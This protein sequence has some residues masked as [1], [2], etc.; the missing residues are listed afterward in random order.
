MPFKTN[1]LACVCAVLL[2]LVSTSLLAQKTVTGRVTSNADKQPVAGAT[3]QVKGTK[4]ATQTG[5]DGTFTITSSKD[6]GVLVITVVGFEA[7]QVPVS[8]RS[9]V[10]D[11]VLSL[12]ATSLNDVVV[13]GYTAQKKKEITGAI[14]VVN[15]KDLKSVPAGTM[16]Q[17]LQ[18]QAAG[19]NI[20]T[21]GNP[22]T[23]SDVFIRGITSFGNVAPLVVV[24]GVQ[25]APGDLTILTDLSA[26]DIESIQVLKDAQSSIYGTRGSAGV[27]LVTTKRGRGKASI[28]YDGYYGTQ[29]PKTGNVWHKANTQ[30][31]AD[32][33]FLAAQNSSA[34]DSNGNVVS[35]QYGTGTT[36]RLPDYIKVGANSGQV[37]NAGTDLSLYN[38]DYNKGPIY[39]IVPANTKGGGTDW[40]GAMMKP[41]PIQSHTVTASGGSDRS[42]YLFSVNYFDQEGTMLNTYLKRYA[43]RMN[44]LFNVKNNIRIGENAYVL[45]KQ[46]PRINNNTEG[47]EITQTAW[48]QPIIPVFDAGGGFGGTAGS[49]LGNTGSPMAARVRAASNKDFDWQ[50]TGDVFAEVDFLKHFTIKTLFGGNFENYYNY[51]HGFHTYEN[52]ENSTTNTYNSTSGYNSTWNWTNTL[53]YGNIFAEKHSLKV[54][55][56]YESVQTRNRYMTAGRLTYFSDDPNYVQLATGGGVGTSN[57]DYYNSIHLSSFLAKLDYAYNDKYLLG[58]NY[59]N[60]GASV[61][62]PNTRYG[63]FYSVSLG[64]VLSQ[65]EFMKG[66]T[67]INNLKVRG[68]YGILGSISNVAANNQYNLYAGTPGTT[69]YDLAGASSSSTVG[70]TATQYGNLNTGWEKDK[71]LDIGMDAT[72]INNHLDFSFDW[73]QKSIDGLL[74]QDQPPAVV[75]GATP[76]QVNI[77]DMQNTGFDIT[78][79]YHTRIARDWNFNIGANIGAYK[80][81]IVSIPGQAGFFDVAQTHNTGT[82]VR[83]Q[84]GHPVGSFFGYK[85]VGIFQDAADV[86]K[87]PTEQDAAPGRFKYLDANKDGVIDD[88]D[89]VFYGNPNP[90]FVYGINVGLSWRQLDFSAMFYGSQGNSIFNYQN[91]FQAFYPQFQNAKNANLVTDS[92]LPT[93]T[94]TNIPIVENASYFSTNGVLNNYFIEDGS[95]FRCKQLQIGY[96]FTPAM[97]KHVGIDRARIYIQGANLFTITGYQGLDPEIGSQANGTGV[98][99]AQS[100]GIDYSNYPPMKTYLVGVSLTF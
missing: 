66:I 70:F 89:R 12:S 23:T 35:A 84:Q 47:N 69:G 87:S 60:D 99:A 13:T 54:L 1:A 38:N 75:G 14:S 48:M 59:R 49:E 27:I 7:M 18:G 31:M 36:P 5:A 22:G 32:L 85:I 40:W 24:D 39:L 96:N 50:V 56:G 9:S 42:S 25:S 63:D 71:I 64:W 90:D 73:Y 78:I 45:Y 33:Y 28:T 15:V 16:E 11:L 4:T 20:L 53:Q 72:I 62:G 21:S 46:N 91:Y 88:K 29:Q 51:Q 92:W 98:P 2:L 80:S 8:G 82:M 76:P 94:H 34:L 55:V 61:F 93:R 81:N 6:I 30:Q 68:S 100:F 57:N 97:L 86:A 52:A 83:N 95:Y 44:T 67:F 19:V 10:G 58:I 26:N 65:E 37:G 3:V 77:G 17:M 43:A 41:A 79:N 74:F